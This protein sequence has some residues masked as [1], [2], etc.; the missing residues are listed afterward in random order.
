MIWDT[1]LSQ[2]DRKGTDFESIA[3]RL[4]DRHGARVER[5]LESLKLELKPEPRIVFRRFDQPEA[6]SLSGK[7]IIYASDGTWN[8]DVIP[9]AARDLLS[10]GVSPSAW[11][12]AT[13]HIG[14]TAAVA[15]AGDLA[16]EQLYWAAQCV[17]ELHWINPEARAMIS[18]DL[19]DRVDLPVAPTLRAAEEV[20][21]VRR[22][23]SLL[24][25]TLSN[26]QMLNVHAVFFS[27]PPVHDHRLL[28]GTANTLEALRQGGAILAGSCMGLPWTHFSSHWHAGWDLDEREA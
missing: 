3:L 26:G 17:S 19:M 22:E 16:F 1:P 28:E 23:G 8:L 12:D 10:R 24:E 27:G 13:F 18:E 11:I 21:S 4:L 7:R 14:K 6:E 5:D 25:L 15:G 2:R 20:L 9:R